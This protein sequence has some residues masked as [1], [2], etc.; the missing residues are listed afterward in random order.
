MRKIIKRYLHNY[1]VSDLKRKMVF[2]AGPRQVG[3][4]TLALSIGEETF[5]EFSYLNWD[6][7]E[8]RR[9]I[10]QGSWPANTKLI[11]LD[12]LHKYSK[13]KSFIKGEFD[14]NKNRFS[15]LITGSAR[16]DIYRKSGDSLMGRY[17]LYRLHPFSL[18]ELAQ[19]QNNIKPFEE[20][21]FSEIK[22]SHQKIFERLYKFG[23]FPEPFISQD[24]KTLRRFHNEYPSRLIYEDIRSIELVR[25]LS[26]ME[27]LSEILPTKIGAPLS[28]NSLR[29]D[30]EVNH[31]TVS[32]WLDI[33]ERFYYI[34]R[35]TPFHTNIIRS[36]KKERKVYLWDWSILEDKGQKIENMVASHLLKLCHFLYDY[37]GY[38]AHLYYFRNAYG[39]ELDFIITINKKPWF[40]VEVKSQ[41]TKIPKHILTFKEK[42]KIPYIYIVTQQNTDII[43][44]N[45]RIINIVKFLNGLI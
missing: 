21:Q 34:F 43:Q 7:I 39:Q 9:I 45:V 20:L 31:K 24:E 40:A 38:K 44:H 10:K 6:N 22:K 37:Y 3:K 32:L 16:L 25:D 12:E 23:G 1:I 4:T 33:L 28:I 8:D 35:I 2:I 5:K 42:I 30:L 27:I 13:W 41:S 29:E 15:F 19:T 17:Y 36:I 26:S 14:K 18:A 11:I